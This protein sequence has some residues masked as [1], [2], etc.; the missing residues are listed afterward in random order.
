[1]SQVLDRSQIEEIFPEISE[2]RNDRLRDGVVGIWQDVAAEMAWSELRAI[3]K[4]NT[5]EKHRSLVGHVRGVTQMAIGICEVAERLHG[6]SY[7][8]DLLVAAC[9]LHDSSKPVE[10]EPADHQSALPGVESGRSSPLGK[11]LPHAV[12]ATHMILNRGLP[13]ALANL[14]A[15]HTHSV[16][17]RGRTWEAAA[18]F[19]ADFADSDVARSMAGETM[20]LERWHL[21]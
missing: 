12:Y 17:V 6:R 20:Y 13:L 10:S 1:M 18:L 14:V 15:T 2:I 11:N 9:L 19:Y 4:N 8:R 3:P 5:T 16:N 21:G 7:D